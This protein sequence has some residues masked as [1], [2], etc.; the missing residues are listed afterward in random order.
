MADRLK[1]YDPVLEKT[2]D[3][4]QNPPAV[5]DTTG[6]NSVTQQMEEQKLQ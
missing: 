4:Q 6:S 5:E 3:D 1:Y 2:I